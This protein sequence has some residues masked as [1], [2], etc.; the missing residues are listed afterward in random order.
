M[1]IKILLLLLLTAIWDQGCTEPASRSPRSDRTEYDV[2]LLIG[3]SNMAGRGK[4]EADDLSHIDGVWL[5]DNDDRPTPASNPLN[6][7]SSVR[8]ELSLQQIG[9]GYTFS[10]EIAARTGHKIL[11]VVNALGGSSI[12][13]WSKRADL[14]QDKN[15]IG[16]NRRQ[17]YE[18]ILVR[19]RRARKYGAIKAILWHQ[20]EANASEKLIPYYMPA[21]KQFVED[22]RTDLDMPYLPFIAGELGSWRDNYVQFNEMLHS[23]SSNI[24]FSSYVSSEGCAPN[25][26]NVHFTREAQ[27]LLGER[28][29]ERVLEMCY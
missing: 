21:L 27:F 8:K 20:G 11:L 17:L 23:I 16:Y 22:L 10:R 19:A 25:S 15:S 2:F 29:A 14:I 28:Y 9:P 24:P 3:Q 1:K 6:R 26:D 5:L 12:G 18:E 13:Q 4:M 7:Y